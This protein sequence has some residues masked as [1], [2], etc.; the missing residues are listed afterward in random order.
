MGRIDWEGMERHERLFWILFVFIEAALIISML[1]SYHPAL[2][3]VG[4]AMV[5][6]A[7]L[8][9]EEYRFNRRLKKTVDSHGEVHKK[10]TRWLNNEY[11]LIKEL[12]KTSQKS[13]R[14]LHDRKTE[15]DGKM[16]KKYRELAGKVIDLENQLNVMYRTRPAK[17]R[18]ELTFFEVWEGMKKLCRERS[19][20]RTLSRRIKNTIKTIDDERIVLVSE[21]TKK[22]RTVLKRDIEEFWNILSARKKLDF[23]KDLRDPKLIRMGS[24]VIALFAAL[25]YI[26][27][28]LKPR[29]LHLKSEVRH[30][31]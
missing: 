23:R 19:H 10:L 17:P 1:Q 20:I 25:P 22:K 24:I 27:Y 31:M 29:V 13:I 6:V 18:S 30:R 12:R 7:V 14:D 4:V 9:V 5:A 21:L 15:L 16:E 11:D 2:L 26:D 3:F 28:T 8:N